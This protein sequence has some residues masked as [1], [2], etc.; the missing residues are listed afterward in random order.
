MEIVYIYII[1]AVLVGVFSGIITGVVLKYLADYSL[2]HRLASVEA[3]ITRVK[4]GELSQRGNQAKREKEERMQA[5]MMEAMALIQQ[6]APVQ[7]V[8][9]QVAAKYPDIAMDLVKKMR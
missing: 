3:E 5:A 8:I 2:M 4:M 1:S 9:K 6:G 7:D